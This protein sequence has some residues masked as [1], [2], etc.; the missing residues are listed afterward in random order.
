MYVNVISIG[1][2]HIDGIH[3][4]IIWGHLDELCPNRD[5]VLLVMCA[6]LHT[7]QH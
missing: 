4:S 5:E 1:K 2:P 6:L 3:R 7:F